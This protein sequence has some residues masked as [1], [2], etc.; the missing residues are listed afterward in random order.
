MYTYYIACSLIS[1]TLFLVYIPYT[2]CKI[3]NLI[4]I[5]GYNSHLSLIDQGDVSH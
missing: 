5:S 1:T 4:K 3:I 2:L